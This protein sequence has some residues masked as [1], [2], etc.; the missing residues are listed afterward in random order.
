MK[1]Q[2]TDSEQANLV[3]YRK[4]HYPISAFSRWFNK[5]SELPS[6]KYLAC[7]ITHRANLGTT[8]N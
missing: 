7:S 6:L 3:W 5:E 4:F 2:V 1:Q 8:G